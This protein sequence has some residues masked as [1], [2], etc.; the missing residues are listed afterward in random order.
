MPN[1]PLNQH[2]VDRLKPR[3]STYDIRDTDLKGF[4]VRVLPSGKKSYFLQTQ[5]EGQRRWTRI[6][7]ADAMPE[8]QARSQARSLLSG[9]RKGQKSTP[10][11][12]AEIAFEAVA[13]EVFAYYRRHWKPRTLAV[14]LNY[15]ENNIL[16]CFRGR[17]VADITRR[18]VLEWFESLHAKPASAN[19]S[20]PVLSFILRHLRCYGA[21]I[22]LFFSPTTAGQGEFQRSS[23]P[24]C[25]CS[26]GQRPCLPS[27][28]TSAGS[29]R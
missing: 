1:L 8:T 9:I 13:D 4:R 3:N 11:L 10:D 23:C 25:N 21:D 26:G 7:D 22:A 20:L 15:Y 16:P 5:H 2:R 28:S 17:L 14:K 19:R 27:N 6:G 24:A 12:P 18:E 29:M